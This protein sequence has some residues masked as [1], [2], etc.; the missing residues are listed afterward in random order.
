MLL[1]EQRYLNAS[2]N[3]Q[4]KAGLTQYSIDISAS[5]ENR[6]VFESA[7]H[8]GDYAVFIAH[9]NYMYPSRLQ[10]NEKKVMI[11]AKQLLIYKFKVNGGKKTIYL[12]P[13]QINPNQT[14]WTKN[15]NNR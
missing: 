6:G 9:P 12:D 11:D 7:V 15:L 13:G 10:A 4:D 3:L 14:Q 8:N 5:S 2:L 1:R